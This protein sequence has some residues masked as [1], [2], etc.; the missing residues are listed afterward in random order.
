M[1]TLLTCTALALCLHTAHAQA[2]PDAPGPGTAL[3]GAAMPGAVLAGGAPRKADTRFVRTQHLD[4]RYANVSDAQRLDLYLP[5]QGTAPY[6]LIIEIHGGGF[7]LG[8]KS[9]PITPMLQGLHRG[10]A[11]A[12]IQYRLS[13]E[14]RFPAAVHDV[15]AAIRYL[16]A[17]AQRFGLDAQ[18]FAVWGAS[19]GGNLAA[20][21]A[22]SA[23]VAAL[24]DPA[25][26]HADVSDAVQAAVDWFGPL[27]FTTMDAEFAAL[28]KRPAMGA[29]N[30]PGSPESR[31]LGQTI[32]TDAARPLAQAAN[33]LTYLS[34]RAPAMLIQHGTEDRNVPLTQSATLAARMAQLQGPNRVVFDRIEGAGH[35]GAA[36][37]TPENTQ[38]VLDFLDRALQR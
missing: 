10:Y 25:L 38:R 15:K 24:S 35:G 31:Y 28:G 33:P 14:A 27:D 37:E 12:S 32:G 5:N 29:T 6:P 21:A 18:R 3:P 19:A 2:L 22:L 17:N 9:G 4:L 23:D 8:D 30:T 16:R 36:F 34:A 26:G 1:K 7:F 11:V 13:G 20:M